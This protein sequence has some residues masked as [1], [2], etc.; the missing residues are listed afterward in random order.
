MFTVAQLTMAPAEFS[1]HFVI[2]LALLHDWSN[3]FDPKYML[4]CRQ[5]IMMTVMTIITQALAV[6]LAVHC[7]HAVMTATHFAH[8][9]CL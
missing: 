2:L 7:T 6:M 1:V 9:D 8:T 4:A 3:G 5:Q